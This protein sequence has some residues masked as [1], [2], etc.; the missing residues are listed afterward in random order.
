MSDLIQR[1]LWYPCRFR[2][3]LLAFKEGDYAHV[4]IAEYSEGD[5]S[6]GVTYVV[7]ASNPTRVAR[8]SES[9]GLHRMLY[10]KP[11]NRL[12]QPVE[13]LVKHRLLEDQYRAHLRAHPPAARFPANSLRRTRG[14]VAV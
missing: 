9:L 13:D 4:R 14:L 1:S 12:P 10:L 7:L 3:G 11:S 5:L 2:E 8:F 6:G